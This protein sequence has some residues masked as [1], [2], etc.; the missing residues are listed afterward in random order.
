MAEKEFTAEKLNVKFV[1]LAMAHPSMTAE[2]DPTEY[3]TE[4][5]RKAVVVPRRPK[6][7]T[8]MTAEELNTAEK[9]AFLTWRR[10]MANFQNKQDITP[11]ER[12]IEVWRQLWRVLERS[13]VVVQIV[14]A[15]NPLLYR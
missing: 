2:L 12:N 11:F 14:D 8:E 4:A 13:H 10:G 3:M 5:E 9:D 6:W 15:R 7:T 1:S